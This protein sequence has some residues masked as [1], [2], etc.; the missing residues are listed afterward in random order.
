MFADALYI[1]NFKDSTKIL[2]LINKFSQVKGYKVNIQISVALF[3]IIRMNHPKSDRDKVKGK[4][5][6]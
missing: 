1:E 2:A 4:T 6:D 3:Y 5:D